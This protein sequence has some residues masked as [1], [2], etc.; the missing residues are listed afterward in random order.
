MALV[1]L[2]TDLSNFK[3]TN[4]SEAG[5]IQSQVSGRHGTPDAPI[6]NSDFDNGV[7]FGVDP[8]SSPQSFTVRGYTIT[9]DKRFIVNYGGDI[10]ENQGSIYNNLQEFNNISGIGGGVAYYGNIL[11]ITPRGS[12]YRDD[13]G[14]YQVPQ[15]FQN[16]NPPGG[17]SGI[18]GF[19]G[20]QTTLNIPQIVLTGPF[21]DSYQSTLKTEPFIPNAHGSGFMTTPLS[22]DSNLPTSTLTHNV[23]MI[24]LSGP[25][26]QDYQTN[27]NVIPISVD[28]HGSDFFTTPLVNYTSQ[29]SID[30]L[31]TNINSGFDRASMYIENIDEPNTPIFKQFTRGDVGLKRITLTS[32]NFDPFEFGTGLPYVI[33]QHNST[34]PTQFT[35]GEFSD[36]KLI[37]DL[38]GSDF[39]TRPSYTSQ[40]STETATH[41]VT[42]ISLS[43]PT[44]QPYQS[45]INLT[46]VADGAH[47]SN[48][49]TSPIEAFSSRFANQDGML[50]ETVFNSGFDRDKMYTDATEPETPVFKEFKASSKA[51]KRIKLNSPNFDSNDNRKYFDDGKFKDRIP[52]NLKARDDSTTGFDQP[53][54][55]RPIGNTWG[56]DNPEGDGFFADVGGFLSEIDSAAGDI[57]RGAPGFTGLVS[58]TLH[59]AFRLGKFMLTPKGIFFLAK[60]AGLQLLNPREETRIYNP[61]SL[62]SIAPIVHMNRHLSEGDFGYDQVTRLIGQGMDFIMGGEANSP[63][64]SYTQAI[65]SGI[66]F[67]D[68]WATGT[69][70]RT[71]L[72]H[73]A[74][75][76]PGRGGKMTFGALPEL[77]FDLTRGTIE[78]LSP[79]TFPDKDGNGNTIPNSNK[80]KG[81]DSFGDSRYAQIFSGTDSNSDGGANSILTIG[82]MR[83]HG[84]KLL[85][86]GMTTRYGGSQLVDNFLNQADLFPSIATTVAVEIPDVFNTDW[87]PYSTEFPYSQEGGDTGFKNIG[88]T[89]QDFELARKTKAPP[90]GPDEPSPPMVKQH[91]MF[92]NVGDP[93]NDQVEFGPTPYK[94]I[95]TLLSPIIDQDQNTYSDILNYTNE[96]SQIKDGYIKLGTGSPTV[97][98]KF[99]HTSTQKGSD[100]TNVVGQ[101]MQYSYNPFKTENEGFES[102]DIKY[103]YDNGQGLNQGDDTKD[104]YIKRY[105][106]AL[107]VGSPSTLGDTYEKFV[108]DN[109]NFGRMNQDLDEPT[110]LINSIHRDETRFPNTLSNEPQLLSSL[111]TTS[112]QGRQGQS[113]KF[114]QD[115]NNEFKTR[116]VGNLFG[117][118]KRSKFGLI[119]IT[120]DVDDDA[121]YSA[122]NGDGISPLTIYSENRFKPE[123]KPTEHN[124]QLTAPHRVAEVDGTLFKRTLDAQSVTNASLHQR[125]VDGANES[126][127]KGVG[128][129]NIDRYKV[130]AYNEIPTVDEVGN[131]YSERVK[132]VR[133]GVKTTE[134]VPPLMSDS[135]VISVSTKFGSLVKIKGLGDLERME[136]IN[137]HKYGEEDNNDDY[138]KFK[139]YDLTNKKYIIFPAILSGISDSVT[140]EYSSEK[141]VGRPDK[142]HTYI[143][144]DRSI[145]FSFSVAAGS[146]QDLIVCW[147]KLNYL[148]GLTYPT[149]RKIS[150]SNRMD[151]PFISLTIGDMY[152]KLPGYL[153]SLSFTVND[154]S[155]WEIDDGYQLP[156]V[157]DI[158]C[159]FTHIGS[160]ILASQGKHFDL[161]W[162]REFRYQDGNY[163][164][165]DKR[166]GVSSSDLPDF[167]TLLG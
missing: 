51:L 77:K 37:P 110:I 31:K 25:T 58:R 97:L 17:V 166:E 80:Y 66:P 32:P 111:P 88:L 43:G 14:N 158:E 34:G 19:Q 167:Q 48:F 76:V 116:S 13:S 81:I 109:S 18:Q 100:T 114:L 149:W 10:I 38:H 26:T 29:F 145:S 52:Y 163:E 106:D 144:T 20:T 140:P 40:I 113:L 136:R 42:M 89:N 119:N 128:V 90:I 85:P 83:N 133:D 137:R 138:I 70:K 87:Q 101:T 147:E 129:S 59:D 33:P 74:A 41:D 28:A 159:E 71:T 8:N 96:L 146:K 99:T 131:R 84:L 35:I 30:D 125:G 153:N 105:H 123:T 139:F 46:P 91:I 121:K 72:A 68:G 45:T 4:Y 62:G 107:T 11:P 73:L 21:E 6:D 151:A 117:P 7:G 124:F 57:V 134:P 120:Q 78:S 156:K 155:T 135:G 102:N 79:N 95:D 9:G 118:R 27:I 165:T 65:K 112:T 92:S 162:L 160:H 63:L 1:D 67:D 22:N 54:V 157:V 103:F 152:N 69:A 75:M 56:L 36:S 94:T 161:P 126:K 23:S 98:R 50:M 132:A 86:G 154:Q 3:Y 142:I 15:E 39:M 130:L 53:F 61:L 108:L 60:Q 24:N 148:M 143:G 5:S 16:T 12:I 115:P 127:A 164:L 64:G 47:G 55:I 2:L 150:N 104:G 44:T 49:L 93:L 122:T 82:E 141:Y